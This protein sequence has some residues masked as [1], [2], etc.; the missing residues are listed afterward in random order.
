MK[1]GQLQNEGGRLL[2]LFDNYPLITYVELGS[3]VWRARPFKPRPP[4]AMAGR[5]SQKRQVGE[6]GHKSAKWII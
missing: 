2:R 3:T 5:F 4:E 1:F 6:M